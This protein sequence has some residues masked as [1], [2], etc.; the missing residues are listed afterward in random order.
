[1]ARPKDTEHRI[2]SREA[3]YIR[4][5]WNHGSLT[6][7]QLID[8]LP[9][10]H[11]HINTVATMLKSLE[12]KG[13]I[14][15]EPDTRPTRYSAAPEANDYGRRTLS[16]VIRNFFNDSYTRVISTLVEDEKISLDELKEIVEIMEQQNHPK[17]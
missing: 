4:Y 17:E 7:R 10:P 9:E 3:E 2:S 1:M 16:R 12:N 11:P 13:F 14:V 15:R 6:I 8:L 5:F